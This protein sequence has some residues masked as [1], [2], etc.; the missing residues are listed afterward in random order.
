MVRPTRLFLA[1]ATISPV[2]MTAG[3][4]ILPTVP[5]SCSGQVGCANV[6]GLVEDAA[7]GSVLPVPGGS[8]EIG[9]G[10]SLLPLPI[11]PV[12]VIEPG[13]FGLDI[14]LSLLL[15][16]LI[17][18]LLSP[19]GPRLDD[20]LT[21]LERLCLAGDDPDFFCRQRYGR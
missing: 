9:A 1:V 16:G 13:D 3:C 20:S 10:A 8:V 12:L 4:G 11:P 2:W 7:S 19:I 18:E 6:D 21:F 14:G 17:L 15:D 5:F